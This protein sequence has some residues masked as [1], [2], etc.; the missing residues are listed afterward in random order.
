MG[1]KFTA[2]V[3]FAGILALSA[4]AQQEETLVSSPPVF[5]KYGSGGCVGGGGQIVYVPGANFDTLRPCDEVCTEGG[6]TDAAGNSVDPCLPP[7]GQQD[8]GDDDSSTGGGGQSAAGGP[9]N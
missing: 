8:R 3:L 2:S 1:P 6:F 7:P 4:C 5:D 9:L